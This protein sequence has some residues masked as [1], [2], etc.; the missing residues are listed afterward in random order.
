MRVNPL[1]HAAFTLMPYVQRR[2]RMMRSM[3]PMAV[4]A[5]CLLAAH[6]IGEAADCQDVVTPIPA[7]LRL[8]DGLNPP[9]CPSNSQDRT[10]KRDQEQDDGAGRTSV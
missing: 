7:P 1:P 9:D 3:V 10:N 2:R 6:I 5:D 8:V 4:E